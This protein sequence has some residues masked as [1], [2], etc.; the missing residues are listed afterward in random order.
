[1]N[2]TTH[3]VSDAQPM[4]EDPKELSGDSHASAVAKP[5]A[6]PLPSSPNKV[7][8]LIGR[9]R[10]K[11]EERVFTGEVRSEDK[12]LEGA[13]AT[14]LQDQQSDIEVLKAANAE[15]AVIIGNQQSEISR[16]KEENA[17]LRSGVAEMLRTKC[18]PECYADGED[19]NCLLEGKFTEENS[20]LK[21]EIEKA[22][23]YATRLATI[24][25]SKHYTA[26]APNWS[27]LEDLLGVLTQIDN[28]TSGLIRTETAEVQLASL[29]AAL[30]ETTEELET[31]RKDTDALIEEAREEERHEAAALWPEWADKMLKILRGFGVPCDDED[32]VD[33]PEELREWLEIYGAAVRRSALST[34]AADK[35]DGHE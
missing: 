7:E 32:G 19:P 27:P 11:A 34:T 6:L 17:E 21:E 15:Q 3:S 30:D 33:L 2:S 31:L 14:L 20:R 1:M 16:L 29:K 23:T 35:G 9:L 12:T 18:G 22:R 26:D 28:M 10:A 13:A 25:W 24:L 5:D 4:A 8:D